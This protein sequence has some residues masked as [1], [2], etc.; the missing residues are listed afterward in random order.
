MKDSLLKKLTE[1][2]KTVV[3]FHMPG[4]KRNFCD[5][6]IPYS[7][8]ITEIDGFDNLHDMDGVLKDTA[9]LAKNIYGAYESFPLVN[10]S[11]CGV[12]AGIYSLVRENKNILIARNCHKSVYNAAEILGLDTHYVMPEMCDCD[13]WGRVS[14]QKVEEEIKKHNIGTVVVTSP[15]YDGVISDIAAI[16]GVCKRY[17]AYLFVDYAHG[18]HMFDLHRECDVAVVSLHKTLPS[19]TQT[20]LLNVYSERVDIDKLKHG[21][22]IFETSSPSYVLLASIDECLRYIKGNSNDFEKTRGNLCDFYQKA[23]KLKNI[24]ITHF[25][26][27]TKIIAFAE[28]G[29]ELAEFLREES[30]EPEMASEKYVLLMATVCDTT[31][32]L[33][34]LLDALFKIDK[35]INALKNVKSIGFSI[36]KCIEKISTALNQDGNFYDISECVGKESLEYIWAYPPG[37]PIVV[38]GE[39]ITQEIIEYYKNKKLKSTKGKYPEIYVK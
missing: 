6:L 4:H 10:G 27:M 17:D 36:P 18:A 28:S 12:L 20:A 5:S 23:S 1:Y 7:I 22:S 2:S 35:K 21:L 24:R 9:D 39:I 13:I 32:S 38:P 29:Y 8:D 30:I 37:A 26:D 34:T 31:E 15:T 14:P 25:D 3:P 19:L 16:Y 33:K 11:T